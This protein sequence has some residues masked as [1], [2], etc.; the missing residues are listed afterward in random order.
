[1]FNGLKDSVAIITGAGGGLGKAEAKRLAK[2]GCKIFAVDIMEP[3]L[4]KMK[5][6]FA[7]E[8]LN[9]VYTYVCDGSKEEEVKLLS[10]S[11]WRFMVILRFW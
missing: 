8:G 3:G 6:E 4:E 11:A 2:E 7:A 1:M 5:A 9:D 10:Q